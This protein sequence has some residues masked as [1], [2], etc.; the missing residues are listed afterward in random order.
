M[1]DTLS[2]VIFASLAGLFVI[3]YYLAKKDYQ[4]SVQEYQET[5][6]ELLRLVREFDALQTK[7]G[8]D[9]PETSS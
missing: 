9:N 3:N 8:N 5:V 1:S 6:Q 2:T 7:S 4:K